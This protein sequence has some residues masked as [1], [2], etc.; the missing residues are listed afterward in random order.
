MHIQASSEGLITGAGNDD[1]AHFGVDGE[2]VNDG[3]E[4]EP[5]GLEEGIHLF[6]AVDLDMGDEGGGRGDEEVLVGGFGRHSGGLVGGTLKA[7]L[8]R[9]KAK[10]N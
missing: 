10:T 3:F 7:Q 9:K 4:L 8:T 2:G 1:G 6:R 5:H